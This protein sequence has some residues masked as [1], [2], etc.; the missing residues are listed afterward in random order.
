MSDSVATEVVRPVVTIKSSEIVETIPERLQ[1]SK[2]TWFQKIDIYSTV[3][4]NRGYSSMTLDKTEDSLY[5]SW[6]D[7]RNN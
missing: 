6:Y 1:I 3:N 4:Q 7:A 5:F 2:V